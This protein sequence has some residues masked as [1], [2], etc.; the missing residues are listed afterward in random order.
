MLARLTS[1][2]GTTTSATKTVRPAWV[3]S[4]STPALRSFCTESSLKPHVQVSVRK[5]AAMSQLSPM[6][7][8]NKTCAIKG[9]A[10]FAGLNDL[11]GSPVHSAFPRLQARYLHVKQCVRDAEYSEYDEDVYDESEADT[12]EYWSTGWSSTDGHVLRFPNDG[13]LR[14]DVCGRICKN[15]QA[16]QK[17]YHIHRKNSHRERNKRSGRGNGKKPNK[18]PRRNGNHA[19]LPPR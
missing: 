1:M 9:T 11:V 18:K 6:L 14:C 15:E 8:R 19:L 10:F 3:T 5:A 17:H 16:L 2:R 12:V 7:A 13:K 4:R